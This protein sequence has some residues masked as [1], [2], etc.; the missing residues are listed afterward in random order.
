VAGLAQE[1]K[2]SHE[3]TRT[4]RKAFLH[5]KSIENRKL[6][7]FSISFFKTFLNVFS[8]RDF[9]E[10]ACQQENPFTDFLSTNESRP[11]RFHPHSLMGPP[12]AP[13]HGNIRE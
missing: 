7:K 10:K 11:S 8:L 5:R 2:V 13:V 1:E 12:F 6:K 4:R 3:A 9:H